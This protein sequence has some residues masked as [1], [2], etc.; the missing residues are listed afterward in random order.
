MIPSTIST[1]NAYDYCW[2]VREEKPVSKKTVGKCKY[3]PQGRHSTFYLVFTLLRLPVLNLGADC[4]R[5]QC[6]VSTNL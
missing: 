5:E 1:T 2:C 6:Y 3:Y 4:D